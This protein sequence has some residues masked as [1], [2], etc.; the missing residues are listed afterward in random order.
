[1]TLLRASAFASAPA[2]WGNPHIAIFFR[3]SLKNSCMK[4][5]FYRAN[6]IDIYVFNEILLI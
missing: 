2:R 5:I 6:K 4:E 3:G 1:M